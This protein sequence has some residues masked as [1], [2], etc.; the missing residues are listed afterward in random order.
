MGST[1]SLAFWSTFSMLTESERAVVL[2][3]KY[4]FG[5]RSNFEIQTETIWSRGER[6]VRPRETTSG[7]PE[8]HWRVLQTQLTN[9]LDQLKH[10]QDA[11]PKCSLQKPFWRCYF[12]K[13]L[14][15]HVNLPLQIFKHLKDLWQSWNQNLKQSLQIVAKNFEEDDKDL[16][17]FSK[18]MES[19]VPI[20]GLQKPRLKGSQRWD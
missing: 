11:E 10:R 16:S 14:I 20:L 18:I 13:T 2:Q 6:R 15:T 4:Q 17:G 3:T 9:E 8:T 5:H 7:T 1:L 19:L 12:Y